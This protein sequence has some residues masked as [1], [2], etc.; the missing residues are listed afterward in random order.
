MALHVQTDKLYRFY[1]GELTER[2]LGAPLLRDQGVKLRVTDM[3]D[4][5]VVVTTMAPGRVY[6]SPIDEAPE[7]R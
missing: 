3:G 4:L 5:E 6:Q 2:L 7:V 1:K